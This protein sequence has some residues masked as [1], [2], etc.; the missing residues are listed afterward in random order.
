MQIFEKCNRMQE[1]N[2]TTLKEI[3][4]PWILLANAKLISDNNL[5]KIPED[6]GHC[7]S[8]DNNLSLMSTAE[9]PN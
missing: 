2:G 5:F 1:K 8:L 3:I 7:P 4:I 9:L 6:L